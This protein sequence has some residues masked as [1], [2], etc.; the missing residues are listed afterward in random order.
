[1]DAGYCGQNIWLSGSA[2]YSVSL[3]SVA[4]LATGSVLYFWSSNPGTV[5]L[6]R[7]GTDNIFLKSSSVSSITLGEGDSLYLVSNPTIGWIAFGGSKQI[8][9][10]A[11]FASSS[12]ANGYQRIP[13]GQLEC[14]GSFTSSATAGGAVPVSFPMGFA[15]LHSLVIT[16]NSASTGTVS[17]WYDSATGSGFN[18][19]CNLASTVCTYIAKGN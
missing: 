5:T 17:A 7:V 1:M 16:P 13:G 10:S 9:N 12:G 8:G 2:N 4:N 18:G 3:P 15:N 11:T 14:R 19:H 6:N